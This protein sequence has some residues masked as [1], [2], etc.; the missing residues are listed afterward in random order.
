ML[1]DHRNNPNP[2]PLSLSLWAPASSSTR[3][4]SSSCLPPVQSPRACQRMPESGR[5]WD[6]DGQAV[7][8]L[9]V[10]LSTHCGQK[11][12]KDLASRLPKVKGIHPGTEQITER[13]M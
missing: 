8:H 6:K 7:T 12:R 5:G 3:C 13:Q 11:L 2:D 1:T 10:I 9:L 4:K